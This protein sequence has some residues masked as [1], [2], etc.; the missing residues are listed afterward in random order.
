MAKVKKVT[1]VCYYAVEIDTENEMPDFTINVRIDSNGNLYPVD[2]S[3]FHIM[4]FMQI[5]DKK[6]SQRLFADIR[7]KIKR[8]PN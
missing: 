7:K 1:P 8:I 2:E 4:Q 6:L 3:D 5:E